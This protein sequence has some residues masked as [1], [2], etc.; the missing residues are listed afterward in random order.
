MNAF[1]TLFLAAGLVLTAIPARGQGDKDL[2][3]QGQEIFA[4]N[5]AACHRANGEGLPA[6]FPALKG[7]PFVQGDPKPVLATVVHGRVGK[8]GQMPAWGPKLTDQEIA[9]V[10]SYI[11]NAW[12]N[13]ASIIHAEAVAAA[14]KKE[15]EKK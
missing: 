5:C 15:S 4:D 6:K 10:V 14:R 11:R 12:S 13:K 3:K 7:N 1:A 8:L 9:A 2:L